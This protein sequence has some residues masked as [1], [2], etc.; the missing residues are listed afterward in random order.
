M[1]IFTAAAA[2]ALETV[3]SSLANGVYAYPTVLRLDVS[4]NARN[5]PHLIS[6]LLAKLQLDEPNI[7]F[8]D[9]NEVSI[10]NNDLPQDKANFD[11]AFDIATKRNALHCHFIIKSSRTFHQLKV[12]VWDI[13]QKHK[14]W[15]DKSPGPIKKTN[16]V[17]MGF[18]LHVHPGF[19]SPKAFHTQLC[20]D[21]E[22]KYSDPATLAACN[23]SADDL[24][25]NYSQPDVYFASSKCKGSYDNKPLHTN[26]LC[27]YGSKPDFDRTTHMITRLSSF[28]TTEDDTTPM[29]VP[30]ALKLSHPE[31]YG[32]YLAKQ[33]AFLSTHRNI[34]IVG[35]HPS[36]MDYGD[37]SSRD[38]N[39]PQSIWHTLSAMKGVYRVDSC[40]RTF[41]LGKWNISCH[42]DHHPD[43]I[44]WIDDHLVEQWHKV[45]LDLPA[46]MEFPTPERLSRSRVPHSVASGL[47][48]ASPVSHYLKSLAARNTST[49]ILSVVRNPWRQTPPVQ[50]VQYSFDKDAYPD[51]PA[52]QHSTETARTEDSTAA[53]HSAITAA[54]ISQLSGRVT[55][56]HDVVTSK[57]Q[58][59][60]S[61]RNALESRFRDRMNDIEDTMQGIRN[62][63]DRIADVVTNRLLIGLTRENGLLWKQDRKIDELQEKL[64]E[65]LPLVKSALAKNTRSGSPEGSPPKKNRRLENELEHENDA[66]NANMDGLDERPANRLE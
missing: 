65:F 53:D 18:W 46:Y 43:I 26:A 61:D 22:A 9:S 14:I 32:K 12:G 4:A 24:P 38:I 40:R 37:I 2:A 27:M 57:L 13:L 36:A 1:T 52:H 25:T 31:V 54:S 10:D 28:A 58:S 34:A 15:L 59:I 8:T 7:A 16:L 19:A 45:P 48:D 60:D 41:D 35:V 33:N 51:L 42:V 47:T 30:F 56:A 29:Y 62:D 49:K 11:N 21:L 5:A 20:N 3:D 44:Q 50:S 66:D 6:L 17:P 55:N 39:C 23:L 64:L 63:L